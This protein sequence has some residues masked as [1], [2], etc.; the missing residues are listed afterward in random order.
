MDLIRDIPVL[1]TGARAALEA[2]EDVFCTH[3]K[4]VTG[5]IAKD[6]QDLGRVA[7]A[8]EGAAPALSDVASFVPGGAVIAAAVGTGAEVA[9]A[10]AAVVGDT[11]NVAGSTALPTTSIGW[12]NY[13]VEAVEKGLVEFMSGESNGDIHALSAAWQD[14]KAKLSPVIPGAA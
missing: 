13:G 14:F 3:A 7:T 4:T 12:L 9:A 1:V 8:I 6:T 10:A 11:L 2:F 5:E